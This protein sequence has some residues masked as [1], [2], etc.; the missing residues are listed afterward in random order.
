VRITPGRPD[1][2][3]TLIEAV[4]VLGVMAVVLAMFGVGMGQISATAAA[5]EAMTVA[6]AQSHNAFLRLDRELRYAKGISRPG[7][8]GDDWYVEYLSAAG[9]V[10]TCAQLRLTA[11]AGQLQTRARRDAAAPGPWTTLAS[12]LS[13][14]A[15]F[16]RTEASSGGN[17]YQQLTVGFTLAGGRASAPHRAV[18]YTFT[19][20]NTSVDTASDVVCADLGRT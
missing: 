10:T 2:G 8:T 9:G 18:G 4:V 13:A 20:L 6:A 15:A 3:F 12:G 16:T 7:R 5:N 1:D 19:A 17:Q 14:P 11:V